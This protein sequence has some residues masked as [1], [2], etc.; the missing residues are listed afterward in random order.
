[1]IDNINT[2]FVVADAAP[3]PSS[4]A[5]A[6]ATRNLLALI[7][8]LAFKQPLDSRQ[9]DVERSKNVTVRLLLARGAHVS[10]AVSTRVALREDKEALGID[11]ATD[12]YDEEHWQQ[13]YGKTIILD[14]FVF[15]LHY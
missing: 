10:S 6:W 5:P 13:Y 11:A 8:Q 14:S 4:T 9:N 3:L 7:A 1:M 2:I 15:I 12:H